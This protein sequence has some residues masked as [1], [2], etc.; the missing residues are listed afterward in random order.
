VSIASRVVPATGGNDRPL[1]A[2]DRV[3]H[4]RL[5]DVG[6]PDQGDL[7]R[8]V[9]LLG[10]A[11]VGREQLDDPVQQVGDA[12]AGQRG[13]GKHVAHAEAVKLG[14][15]ALLGGVVGLV[16]DDEDWGFAPAQQVARS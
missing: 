16:D 10:L 7:D 9:V 4:R 6:P 11:G 8:F 14:G 3:Q 15:V 12:A 13:N 5:A 1:F 2:Q